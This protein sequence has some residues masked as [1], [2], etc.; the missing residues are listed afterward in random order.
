[1]QKTPREANVTDPASELI[2]VV[3]AGTMGAGIAQVAAQSGRP[4]IL[5]DIKPEYVERGL[6][7]IRAGLQGRVD[8]GKLAADEMAAVLARIQPTTDRAALAPARLVV[9]AAPE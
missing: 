1:M 3:G 5:Y 9:E 7:A 8:K 4:V 6:A 2:G